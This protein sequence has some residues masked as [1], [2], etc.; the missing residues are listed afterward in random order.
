MQNKVS[1]T[2]TQYRQR[3]ALNNHVHGI[4]FDKELIFRFFSFP[5]SA[6]FLRADLILLNTMCSCLS[7]YNLFMS[8]ARLM[9]QNLSYGLW[10]G[11]KSNIAYIHH[12]REIDSLVQRPFYQPCGCEH[13]QPNICSEWTFNTRTKHNMNQY[14]LYR[15]FRPEK[16]TEN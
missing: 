15:N 16:N 5:A 2:Q 9:S 12:S 10:Y 13:D 8:S 7:W 1:N 11:K 3:Y 4:K 14:L 6:R